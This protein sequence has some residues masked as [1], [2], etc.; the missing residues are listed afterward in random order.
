MIQFGLITKPNT[1]IFAH[2][3]KSRKKPD[4]RAQEFVFLSLTPFPEWQSIV[5]FSFIPFRQS[6]TQVHSV[7]PLIDVGV[8]RS[9]VFRLRGGLSGSRNAFLFHLFMPE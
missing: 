3:M 4:L 6:F 5:G 9:I 7:W 8:E 1:S 2:L